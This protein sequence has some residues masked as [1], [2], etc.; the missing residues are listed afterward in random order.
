MDAV[1]YGAADDGCPQVPLPATGVGVSSCVFEGRLL[2]GGHVVETSVF[3]VDALRAV[4]YAITR[5]SSV[6]ICPADP[7]SPLSALIAAAAHVAAMVAIRTT[8]GQATPSPLRV[9]VVTADY[10]LRGF[11]RGLAVRGGSGSG[12]VPMRSIVPAATVGASGLVSVIDRE[13]GRWS[14]AFVDSVDAAL[15][16]GRLDLLV[17]DLPVGDADELT[18]TGVP[19]VV[20]ARDP[21]DRV[22]LRLA[23]QMAVF[24]YD[25]AVQTELVGEAVAVGAPADRLANRAGRRVRV[26]P[27]CAPSVCADAGLFWGDVA[28]LVRLAG[29][30]APVRKL[31]ADAFG[32]FHDLIGLAMPVGVYDQLCGRSL[33]SRIDE[34]A[35]G[36]KIVANG[37][38]RT[39]WLPMVEA[40]LAGLLGALRAAERSGAAGQAG[41]TTKAAVLTPVLAEALDEGKNV[42][43][44]TRTEMLARAYAH[45]LG[46]RWPGVRVASLGGLV[47]TGPADLAVLLGMAPTW[48]RWVYRSGVGRELAVLAYTGGQGS[49]SIGVPPDGLGDGFDEA[50]LVAKAVAGQTDAALGMSAPRQRTRAFAALRSGRPADGAY[51]HIAAGLGAASV[52]VGVP[53][54]AEVPPGLWDGGGWTARIEPDPTSS[55]GEVSDPGAWEV[56]A[57]LRVV[58]TDGTW[59][60]LHEHSLVWRWLRHGGRVEQVEAARLGLG[61][62][63]VFIDGDAHKTLLAK[64]LQVTAQVPEL[65]VAAAWLD[66]WRSALGRARARYR[67]YVALER[68][69]ALLGCAVQPQTVRLWCVGSTI[70]PDDPDDVRR[71]GELLDDPILVARHLQVWQAMRTL[72]RAHIRL[73]RRLADLT[74]ALGP[75]AATGR[76]PADEILDEASGLTAGD[77]ETAVAV[78]AVHDITRAAAVPRILVGERRAA[79][80]PVDLICPNLQEARS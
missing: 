6:L 23:G 31:I 36:A 66:Y 78:A 24:G 22:A 64:V 71:L 57:G 61:D 69:L 12:G 39:E 48:G 13:D 21:A 52:E 63:V 41:Y 18:R 73:G 47:D 33:H 79:D 26:V 25:W 40:E 10:H 77:I 34:L 14:T 20:V 56:S 11:Y 43:V 5:C 54:P 75:A 37:E 72:R 1:P 3:D 65:A 4:E 8:S 29:R 30:S 76:L 68:A 2:S 38:L 9:A 74:R 59:A 32:L 70:G 62:A 45:H 15:R 53:R 16:L 80:E 60:W 46:E 28:S 50:A 49:T 42:L 58:F 67:T 17:V 27:V 35:R 55:A 7:L 44:V 19:T 51:R